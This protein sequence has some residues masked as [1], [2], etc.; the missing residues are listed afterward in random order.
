[1]QQNRPPVDEFD[2][3]QRE[4]LNHEFAL[5]RYPTKLKR[6][7]IANRIQVNET[8]VILWFRNRRTEQF[9]RGTS[10]PQAFAFLPLLIKTDMLSASE[11]AYPARCNPPGIKI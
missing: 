10:S 5:E 1:M 9:N 3:R 11:R 8:K 6:Q 7:E 4:I 2:E